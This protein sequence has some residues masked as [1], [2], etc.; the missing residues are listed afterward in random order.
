MGLFKL[1]VAG[2]AGYA[3]YRLATRDQGQHDGRVAFAE[4]ETQG[5]N[6]SK[7]RNAGPDSMRS[8]LRDWD[9]V[10]QATDESFPAS[11]P[12]ATY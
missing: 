1:A 12:P 2:G 9:K 11:D 8:D 10:D 4:G 5:S 3:L 7:V 6:F